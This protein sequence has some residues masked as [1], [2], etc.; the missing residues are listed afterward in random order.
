MDKAA[1]ALKEAC[2]PW[3]FG[4]DI[5]KKTAGTCSAWIRDDA[6]PH[7]LTGQVL[8]AEAEIECRCC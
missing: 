7:L 4:M 3:C 6:N 5:I 8:Q 1:K 2:F